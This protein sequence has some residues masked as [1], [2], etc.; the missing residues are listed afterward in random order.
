MFSLHHP[1]LYVI[2]RANRKPLF[3]SLLQ[4]DKSLRLLFFSTSADAMW[5]VCPGHQQ[6][7]TL[8]SLLTKHSEVSGGSN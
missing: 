4:A 7:F 6:K 5:A 8:V 2:R 3:S 1:A